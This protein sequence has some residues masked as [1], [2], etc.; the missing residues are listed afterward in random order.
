MGSIYLKSQMLKEAEDAFTRA[1]KLDPSLVDSR[2]KLA[3]VSEIQDQIK[4]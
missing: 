2:R 3:V 1:I 4:K